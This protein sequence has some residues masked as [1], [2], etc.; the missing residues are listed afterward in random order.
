MSIGI[1]GGGIGGV[2]AAAA[3]DKFGVHVTVYERAPRL[4]ESGAGMMLRP[5]ATRVLKNLGLLDD[6]AARSGT[7]HHFRVRANCGQ[8]LVDIPLG[9]F[10]VPALCTRR[11]DLL[12]SLQSAVS[13]ERI[14]YGRDFTYLE[15]KKSKIRVHFADGSVAEHDAVVGADGIRSRVRGQLFG[16]VEPR[17]RGYTRLRAPWCLPGRDSACGDAPRHSA[18]LRAV[19]AGLGMVTKL[20]PAALFEHNLRRVYSYEP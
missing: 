3:F 6:I 12:A 1:I 19:V 8:V 7:T 11:A 15:T 5:N 20:L 18:T 17:Y 16:I 14:L 2:A 10:H 9:D 13:A 4:Q